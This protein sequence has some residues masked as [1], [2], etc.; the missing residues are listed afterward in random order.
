LT[1]ALAVGK[2]LAEM[3]AAANDEDME[4]EAH[5]TV[6]T[7]L[8]YLGRV[9]ESLEHQRAVLAIYDLDRHHLSH[10][11]AYGHD[12]GLAACTQTVPALSFLGRIRESRSREAE[13]LA[14]V[15][16]SSHRYSQAVAFHALAKNAVLLR[17]VEAVYRYGRR[18]LDIAARHCFP[19][20]ISLAH[21]FL[22]W[23]IAAR[24]DTDAGIAQA[25]EG[26]RGWFA[27]GAMLGARFFPALI[28]DLAFRA[29]RP[30]EAERWIEEGLAGLEESEDR[31][32]LAELYRVRGEVLAAQGRDDEAL[33][34]FRTAVE[35][36]RWMQEQLHALRAA[37]SMARLHIR[38][39]E[40]AAAAA[41]IEPFAWMLEDAEV[42]DTIEAKEVRAQLVR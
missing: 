11:L 7:S 16:R 9:E 4:L 20:W 27:T 10:V 19:T 14:L 8:F 6:G 2:E 40:P 26:A 35:T 18:L 23:A 29:G 42:P 36:A 15:E 5:E 13:V 24:G 12:P 39:G 38:R 37:T 32:Y 28:A 22:G 1:R 21:F 17:D 25:A 33:T 31:Y 41:A 3:A 34:W 30:E